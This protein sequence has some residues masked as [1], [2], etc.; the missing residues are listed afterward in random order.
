MKRI[1]IFSLAYYPT[2][3]GAEVAIRN[4][5][6]RIPDIA[7]HL[8]TLR[9]SNE[10]RRER[11]GNVEV[12]RVGF[13]GG[14]IAKI[15]YVPLSALKAHSLHRRERFDALWAMM[16]YM[17]FPLVLARLLR[18]RLPYVLT[19]QDGDPFGRVFNRW[20]IVPFRPLLTWGFRHASVVQTISQYLAG[21]ARQGGYRE[22]IE[23]IPNGADVKTF[24]DTKANIAKAKGDVILVSTSRLV[25]KNALDDVIRALARL[26][27][28]IRFV[29]YG[30]G[31]DKKTLEALARELH[32]EHRVALLP[33]PGVDHLPPYLKAADIF[34]RPSRSEGMGISFIEAFAAGIP[35]IATQ[36]GGIADF[37]FDAKRNP[38][39][40][41]TGFAVDK[42]DSEGIA[43]AVEEILKNPE[44][45]KQVAANARALAERYDWRIIARDMK[46]RVFDRVLKEG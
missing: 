31:P 38:D 4:I 18:V 9:F 10:P 44:H 8:I 24:S 25:H 41:P 29:N 39:M 30:F 7:F 26:P 28:H 40:Q 46:S 1:L 23:V 37:L 3:G 43:R 45:A 15:L 2:V 22:P 42:D 16:T 35:V 27:S 36:E 21:W 11:I 33:H 20:Y 19:L 6:D 17:L 12:H 34:I 14:Y 32:V 5:T 13:G